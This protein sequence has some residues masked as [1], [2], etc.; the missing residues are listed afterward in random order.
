MQ[1]VFFC[2][3]HQKLNFMANKLFSL[4][5]TLP[6]P[7]SALHNFQHCT[8]VQLGQLPLIGSTQQIVQLVPHTPCSH[9]HCSY[10]QLGLYCSSCLTLD[11]CSARSISTLHTQ[12]LLS[13]LTILGRQFTHF[14]CL[15]WRFLSFLFRHFLI[16]LL[17]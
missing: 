15:I 7:D 16:C 13:L 2:F 3:H 4:S 8:C 17:A 9:L 14:R 5:H 6:T 12:H 11:I 1:F 10:V